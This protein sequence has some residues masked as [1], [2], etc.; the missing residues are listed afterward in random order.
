[1]AVARVARRTYIFRPMAGP[2]AFDLVKA[3]AITSQSKASP[4]LNTDPLQGSIAVI[5]N[6]EVN[7]VQSEGQHQG[8]GRLI[9]IG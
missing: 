6:I 3:A 1:L 7:G 2:L 9:G 8:Q 5:D 4:V